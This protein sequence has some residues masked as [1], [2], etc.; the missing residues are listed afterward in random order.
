MSILN[1]L[2]IIF[3]ILAIP[4]VYSKEPN[5]SVEKSQRLRKINVNNE[6]K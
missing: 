4:K 2:I 3:I 5:G 1:A 6:N